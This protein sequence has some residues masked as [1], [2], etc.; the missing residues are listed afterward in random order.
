MVNISIV[1][2]EYVFE[3]NSEEFKIKVDIETEMGNCRA[4]GGGAA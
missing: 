4:N 3:G 2:A 1:R